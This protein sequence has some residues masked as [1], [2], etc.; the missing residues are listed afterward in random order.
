[1]TDYYNVLDQM[2]LLT[3]KIRHKPYPQKRHLRGV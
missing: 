2:L 3:D 1:M